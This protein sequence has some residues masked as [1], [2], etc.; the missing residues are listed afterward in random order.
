MYYVPFRLYFIR[1]WSHEPWFYEFISENMQQQ[2]L[3]FSKLSLIL[4][5]PLFFT[6]NAYVSAFISPI[7]IRYTVHRWP[8]FKNITPYTWTS[9]W[10]CFLL[11][12]VA[13]PVLLFSF[14][15]HFYLSFEF[16]RPVLIHTKCCSN[17]ACVPNKFIPFT[18]QK[19]TF[20]NNQIFSV[21][22]VRYAMTTRQ[23]FVLFVLSHFSS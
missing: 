3:K 14:C 23:P 7:C 18:S 19:F 17:D 2:L 10:R 4:L 8:L 12:I 6:Q 15:L 20:T 1:G 11:K 13:L 21:C 9:C 16:R 5:C 22:N